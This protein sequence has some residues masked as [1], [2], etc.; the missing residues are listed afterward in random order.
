ENP[1]VWIDLETTGN[2]VFRDTI[3]EI[4]VIITDQH[5]R[6]A[7]PGIQYVIKT[8]DKT[9]NSMHPECIKMHAD[10]GLTAECKQ[11]PH[12]KEFV[13][14]QVLAYIQEYVPKFKGVI[15]GS[16][17]HFDKTILMREM[18][19]ITDWLKYQ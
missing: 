2:E 12:T 9:L 14:D 5:L 19:L 6:E 10:S 7:H 15:G 11:S 13:R 3:L 16:S 18:P 8:D 17:V 1:I 4:A